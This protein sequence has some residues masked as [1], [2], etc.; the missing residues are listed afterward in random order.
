M[1][2]T[3]RLAGAGVLLMLLFAARPGSAQHVPAEPQSPARRLDTIV[4][5][6]NRGSLSSI[7]LSDAIA[8]EVARLTSSGHLRAHMS[9][10]QPQDR[11]QRK[12]WAARHPV[13]FGTIVG[14][15]GGYL[16]GYLPGDDA[17]FDDFT[18][19]FNGMVMGGIGAGTGAVVGGVIGQTRR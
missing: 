3:T 8:I 18:A 5:E 9:V 12:H 13:L 6:N 11:P 15:V 16:I 10:F 17:V 1:L 4:H 14:F 7:R 19:S 2:L